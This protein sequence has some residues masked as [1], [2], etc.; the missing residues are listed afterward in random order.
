MLQLEQSN[1]DSNIMNTSGSWHGQSGMP[2]RAQKTNT[3]AHFGYSGQAPI[4]P[5]TN[6]TMKTLTEGTVKKEKRKRKTTP[7]I[8]IIKEKIKQSE[9]LIC[10]FNENVLIVAGYVF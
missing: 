2:R 10:C 9:K 3:H 6:S 1:Y 7:R 8:R 5:T 4:P